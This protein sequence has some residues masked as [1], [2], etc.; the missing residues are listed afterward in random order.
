VPVINDA[1]DA[2]FVG[3]FLFGLLFAF[4][5]L[6]FGFTDLDVDGGVFGG[7]DA[8]AGGHDGPGPVNVSTILAFAAWFG[9]VGYLA[10]H[11]LGWVSIVSVAVAVAGG[12]AGS[13]LI[14]QFLV[15]VVGPADKAMNPED[16]RLPGTLARVT[17]PIRS[18]GTGEI[19][20]EQAGSRQVSAARASNGSAIDRGTEVIVLEAGSGIALVEPWDTLVGQ[21]VAIPETSHEVIEAGARPRL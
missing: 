1:L 3:C 10:R 19:V 5:S 11:G 14:Y 17:S 18:G 8:N 7:G 12:L 21:D 20:Y 9:G 6:F 16:Y 2:F 13:A 15:R 4:I